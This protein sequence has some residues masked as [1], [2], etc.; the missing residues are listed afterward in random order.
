MSKNDGI[1]P[2]IDSIII[3][4]GPARKKPKAGDERYLKGRG[5]WQV[6]QQR[7]VPQGMPHAGAMIVS[8]SRPCWEWVDKGSERDRSAKKAGQ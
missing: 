2:R 4:Y 6:R 3:T 7:R 1:T 5:V 8:G